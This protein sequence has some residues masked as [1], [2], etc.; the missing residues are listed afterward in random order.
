[1]GCFH[2]SEENE[3][4]SPKGPKFGSKLEEQVAAALTAARIT[5]QPQYL[6]PRPEDLR[7]RNRPYD[8]FFVHKGR[9]YLIEIDGEQH[10]RHVPF[11]HKTSADFI[12]QQKRDCEK[13]VAAIRYGYYLIRIDYKNVKNVGTIINW[14]FKQGPKTHDYFFDPV[15][16]KYITGSK[17]YRQITEG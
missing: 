7:V 12:N 17:L 9:K 3:P 10:F 2:S 11:F 4:S 8:L 16:Y 1:M 5:F 6:I 14:V 13:T 15:M